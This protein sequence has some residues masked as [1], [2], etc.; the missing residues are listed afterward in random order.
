MNICKEGQVVPNFHMIIR[1]QTEQR[2]TDCPCNSQHHSFGMFF[3][4]SNGKAISTRETLKHCPSLY[5]TLTAELSMC[6][7]TCTPVLPS[8]VHILE[9]L[10]ERPHT[11]YTALYTAPSSYLHLVMH[12]RVSLTSSI[13]YHV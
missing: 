13:I 12:D 3:L 4:Y 8:Y 6:L 10:A 2:I 5:L 11:P 1:I 7:G 9:D